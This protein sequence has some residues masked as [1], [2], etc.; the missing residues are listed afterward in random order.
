M[1]LQTS[2]TAL[3]PNRRLIL[4]NRISHVNNKNNVNNFFPCTG[5]PTFPPPFRRVVCNPDLERVLKPSS[6]VTANCGSRKHEVFQQDGC[7]K[8]GWS[9]KRK[10]MRIS[11]VPNPTIHNLFLG[12]EMWHLNWTTVSKQHTEL[13]RFVSLNDIPLRFPNLIYLRDT[14]VL[15]KDRIQEPQGEL[16]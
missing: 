7:T 5:N 11:H 12:L 8:G 1:L 9:G 13:F 6:C 3:F 4:C 2:G 14:R 16:L 10:C 15:S